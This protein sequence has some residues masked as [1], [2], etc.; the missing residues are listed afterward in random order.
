MASEQGGGQQKWGSA[1]QIPSSLCL[2]AVFSQSSLQLTTTRCPLRRQMVLQK[3]SS[4]RG[5]HGILHPSFLRSDE[6]WLRYGAQ[7]GR[8]PLAHAG[9]P[10]RGMVSLSQPRPP[11]R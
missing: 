10:Q 2:V 9:V 7:K 8:S 5:Q 11:G 3:E 6:P 1:G 4:Q